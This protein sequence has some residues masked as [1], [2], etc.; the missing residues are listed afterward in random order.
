MGRLDKDIHQ[1]E[2]AIRFCLVNEMTPFLEV[3]VQNYRELSDV[4]TVI[5]D[6]DALGVKIDPSGGTR[7]VI[8]DCKTLKN[9]SPINRAFWASGL[10]N[11]SDCN[12]AFIILKKNAS[13]AHRLS[14]KQIGVHLFSE[15]QFN[16]YGQSCSIDFNTDYCYSTCI[17]NWI[18][19]E[20][21]VKGN[22]Q[23]EQFLTFLCN[24]IPLERD[25]VKAFRRFTT[26]L[27]KA[28]GELDPQ[29]PK[30]QAVFYFALSIFAYLMSQIV[31]DLRNIVDFDS[32]EATFEKILKYYIWGGREGFTLKNNLQKVY[33]SSNP[34][35]HPEID[36]ELKM[37]MWSDFIEL[38][39]NLLDSPTDIHKCINPS[40]EL[41]L[42]VITDRDENK[43]LY[44][45]GIIE[46]SNRIRQFSSLMAVYLIGSAELPKDFIE[47]VDSSFNELRYG[48]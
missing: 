6:I 4:S 34:D 9:T 14:A 37:N 30:H 8:F 36:S 42:R 38:C 44:C 1:K 17:D 13:E 7:K 32:D 5:T 48:I 24:E 16:N 35:A 31:H 12:E 22:Q 27:K 40:R 3:N 11:F 33:Y 45:K 2:M 28:K 26:A 43:D 21:S 15:K 20:K 10:M 18:K 46:K 41:G 29:K 39:R 47:I 23:L 19:L 25:C